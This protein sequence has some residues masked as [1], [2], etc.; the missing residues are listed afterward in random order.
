MTWLWLFA[1]QVFLEIYLTDWEAKAH[2]S[3]FGK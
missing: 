3:A 1:K 2:T